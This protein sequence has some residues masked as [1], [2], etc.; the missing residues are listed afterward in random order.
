MNETKAVATATLAG[1]TD[2]T[3]WYKETFRA[4]FTQNTQL[5]VSNAMMIIPSITF[6]QDIPKKTVL[7]VAHS[8]NV[9]MFV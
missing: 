7:F 5:S 3:D 6:R 2:K 4:G 8:L 9:I 1:L